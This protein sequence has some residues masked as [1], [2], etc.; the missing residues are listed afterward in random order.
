[1]RSEAKSCRSF[2]EGGK[3]MTQILSLVVLAAVFAGCTNDPSPSV[4]YDYTEVLGYYDNGKNLLYIPGDTMNKVMPVLQAWISSHP[5]KKV[6]SVAAF[7]RS[8]EGAT[9]GYL[10]VYED[11]IINCEKP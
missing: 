7:D 11:R 8:S 3:K 5:D 6:V 2:S 1:M 9:L 10:V 4:A